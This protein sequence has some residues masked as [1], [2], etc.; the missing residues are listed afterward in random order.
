VT[1]ASPPPLPKRVLVVH[2]SQTGQ[3]TALTEQILAPLKADPRVE[4][5]VETLR[6]RQAYPF[7]WPF[8]RF[9]DVF[10]ESAHLRP[11]QMEPLSLTGEEAFDLVILPYQ[12]WFLAPSPP[13][14]AFLKNPVAQR[15]LAGKPVVSVIACR[16]MWLTAHEKFTALLS[17]TG[18]RLVDNVVLTDTG[19][20]LATFVTTTVWML[21]GRKAGFWGLQ[22]AGL[23]SAQIQGGRRFGRALSD[24]LAQDREKTFQPMLSGLGAVQAD[25]R[26][27]FSERTGTRSFH[28]WGKLLLAA[29]PQG[30]WQRRPLLALYVAFLVSII[31]TVVPVSLCLQALLRPFLKNRL[32]K[33]KTRFERPSGSD[34]DRCHLYED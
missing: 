6:P 13:V 12:V 9:F 28:V 32:D 8:F 30:S 33:M 29:G 3:L 2:Y 27:Y 26:L 22:D 11:P 10:P 15:L 4:L 20:T 17:A 23:S 16:N 1:P 25:P 19:G 5:R 21:S 24:A 14:T 31:V 7:P 18:A 34:T